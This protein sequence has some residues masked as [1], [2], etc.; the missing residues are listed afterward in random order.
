M[1]FESMPKSA[2]RQEGSDGEESEDTNKEEPERWL[3]FID[4]RGVK[5]NVA[6]FKGETDE[7]A[8]ARARSIDARL[9]DESTF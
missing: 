1:G 9:G 8:L 7:D 2:P 6:V 4:N 5:T 3:E